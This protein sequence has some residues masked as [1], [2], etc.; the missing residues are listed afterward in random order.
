MT[1]LTHAYGYRGGPA[2]RPDRKIPT[3]SEPAAAAALAQ[4]N[5]PNNRQQ[6][7]AARVRAAQYRAARE[8][9]LEAACQIEE[10]L[11]GPGE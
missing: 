11:Y 8:Y 7:R 6:L 1:K 5:T 2:Q 3:L 10:E 9:E 4:L